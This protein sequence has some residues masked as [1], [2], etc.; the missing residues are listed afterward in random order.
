MTSMEHF[1]WYFIMYQWWSNDIWCVET[2]WCENMGNIFVPMG[3]PDLI[4]QPWLAA[5]MQNKEKID[6]IN[7]CN[8]SNDITVQ[9]IPLQKRHHGWTQSLA[10]HKQ[11]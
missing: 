7:G 9:S 2:F 4:K 3:A 10:T 1:L 5:T 6:N 8:D 11:H